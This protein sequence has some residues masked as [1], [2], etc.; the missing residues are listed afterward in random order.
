MKSLQSVL[1]RSDLSPR[2]RA[3]LM[4][5]HSVHR[6]VSDEDLFSKSEINSITKGWSPDEHEARRYNKYVDFW[7]AFQRLHRN[8]GGQFLSAQIDS[9]NL[10]KILTIFHYNKNIDDCTEILE[11]RTKNVSDKDP[12]DYILENTGISYD[13]LIHTQTFLSLPKEIQDDMKLID[14]YVIDDYF[15]FNQEEQ[16]A[17]ILQGK[18]ELTKDEIKQLTD[19]IIEGMS[20]EKE[21]L[22][23][24]PSFFVQLLFG[25]SFG[26]LPLSYI[27]DRLVEKYD[28]EHEEEEE[29]QDAIAQLPNLKGKVRFIL[30]QEI[31]DGLFDFYQPLCN[32][33]GYETHNGKTTLPLNELWDIWSRTKQKVREE[34][35]EKIDTGRYVLE[36]R[37]ISYSKIQIPEKIITGTGLYYADDS[38]PY[39]Q[40]Y[41]KQVDTLR[42]Y[43]YLFKEIAES[44]ITKDYA[45]L[46]R[47]VEITERVSQIID[48]DVVIIAERFLR[49][50]RS[51]LET[52]NIYIYAIA[53]SVSHIHQNERFTFPLTSLL[54]SFVI[55]IDKVKPRDFFV[56]ED[57]IEEACQSVGREW[58]ISGRE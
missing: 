52:I 5:Q 43:G 27:T 8:M 20:W 16:L 35:Q 11:Q 7:R 31:R 53:T 18:E 9:A 50:N 54:H 41:K 44:D 42:I 25:T 1:N 26:S 32:S 39:V 33:T 6:Y 17:S 30:K 12:F 2:E 36:K 37:N 46:L 40:D 22:H 28:I 56:T 4:I 57:F 10:E 21:G 14:E 45:Y 49:D 13:Q 29:Q 23:T 38:L 24:K 34:I 55:D 15:Y 48:Q 51:A 3:M 58:K 47:Y 19:M